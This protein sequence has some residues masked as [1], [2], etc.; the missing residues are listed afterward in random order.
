[1][2]PSC[3][4]NINCAWIV[5]SC[6]SI[7]K[8]KKKIEQSKLEIQHKVPKAAKIKK[9][10]LVS[11]KLTQTS[12]LYLIYYRKKLYAMYLGHH[13]LGRLTNAIFR[14]HMALQL[15]PI[16]SHVHTTKIPDIFPYQLCDLCLDI[17]W[18]STQV[19][20]FWT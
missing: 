11:V 10:V 7:F 1:M 20:M 2:S 18:R 12:V 8:K 14:H 6:L 13:M 4:H 16:N 9:V 15:A 5:F 17:L 3:M 19:F